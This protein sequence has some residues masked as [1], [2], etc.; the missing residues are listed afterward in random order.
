M[1]ADFFRI[2]ETM[3]LKVVDALKPLR[4]TDPDWEAQKRSVHEPKQIVNKICD[5]PPNPRHPRSIK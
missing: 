3:I 2:S 5:N 4:R 1:L